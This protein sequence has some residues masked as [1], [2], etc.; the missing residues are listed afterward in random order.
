MTQAIEKKRQRPALFATLCCIAIC[1]FLSLAAAIALA[2]RPAP[3]EK[4]NT[5]PAQPSAPPPQ[6][7]AQVPFH[8]AFG[9]EVAQIPAEFVDNL[10]FLPLSI[11]DSQPMLFELDTTAASTSIDPERLASLGASPFPTPTLNLNGVDFRLS[12]LPA[13]A[14]PDFA[15][16]VGRTY[17]GTLGADFLCC[18]VVEIDYK[19]ETVQLYDPSVYKYTGKTKGIPFTVHGGVPMVRAKF[20]LAANKSFEGDFAIDTALN[21]TVVFTEHYAQSHQL[22][23]SK[24]KTI[25]NTDPQLNGNGGEGVVIGRMQH[26][27]LGSYYPQ[28]LLAAF[29]QK[30]VIAADDPKF[31]GVIGGGMLRRFTVVFDYPH[32]VIYL[33]GN[34]HIREDEQEDKG[35]LTI[36][37]K[38]PTLRTFEVVA[39]QPGTPGHSAGIQKGDI[40]EGIDEDAAADMTLDSIRRLF[41][42]PDKQYK[43][44]L[45]RNG[46]EKQV[47]LKTR[48][49]L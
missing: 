45:D 49:L 33:E 35:G 12:A 40:L 24:I 17:Q 38:G 44:L 21:A 13:M 6:H 20:S 30:D 10:V 39:V 36:I 29:S 2:N 8:F 32:Q 19:R 5:A 48:P 9:G 43:I 7:Q 4:S 23:K 15:S 34:F 14:K 3:Q 1:L 26:F 47:T 16:Q 25:P 42:L 41:R 37:A 28:N 18:V 22:F 27:E 11:N 46:Q 31:A